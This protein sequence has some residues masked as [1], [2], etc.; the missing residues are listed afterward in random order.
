MLGVLPTYWGKGAGK[1]IVRWGQ[2]RA[3]QDG[4]AA[5]LDS[6]Q[7]GKGMYERLGFVAGKEWNIDYRKYGVNHWN[8]QWPM[9]WTPSGKK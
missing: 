2:D 6:T 7:Q 9:S 4:V 8:R 5:F 1:L 3:Q